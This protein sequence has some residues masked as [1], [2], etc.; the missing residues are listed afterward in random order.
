MTYGK[1]TWY[2]VSQ[3][4]KGMSLSIFKINIYHKMII[5]YY[6]VL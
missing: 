1:T 2:I 6:Y 5:G 3:E 4:T